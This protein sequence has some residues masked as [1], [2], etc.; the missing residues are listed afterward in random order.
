MNESTITI[1][2]L[3]IRFDKYLQRVRSG[4]IFIVTK[5]GKPFAY[6]VP[7]REASEEEKTALSQ[8]QESVA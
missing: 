7:A 6:F 1:T 8:S 5:Y 4:E 3:R 2:E